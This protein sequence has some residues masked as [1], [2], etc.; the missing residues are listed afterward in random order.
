MCAWKTAGALSGRT[1]V[2]K[3]R[4]MDGQGRTVDFRN[5][6]II[7]PSNLGAWHLLAG[8]VSK[9]SMEV[10]RDLVM[11]E[12]DGYFHNEEETQY[13]KII[14]EEMNKE[15]LEEQAAKE[16]LAAELAA[17]GIDPEAGKKKRKRNEDMKSS[18]PA[19]TP[20]EATCNM[21][22]RKGLGSKIN[23]GA[24]DE[25]YKWCKTIWSI[26]VDCWVDPSGSYFSWKASAMGK[27][28]Q[29][30]RHFLKRDTLLYEGQISS[31]NIEIGIIRADRE[32][33]VLSPSEIKDFMEEVE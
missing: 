31:N 5:T 32:F 2:S 4:L 22:K 20:A 25:L 30:Q 17:R 8:M 15:Y 11:Q 13:K 1:S 28:C 33:K 9:N 21:L 16:A 24:V 12:V 3:I 26:A 10:A 19:E 23:V 29:M 27:M 7:M 14:W 18:T 6:V